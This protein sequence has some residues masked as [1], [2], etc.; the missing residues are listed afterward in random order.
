MKKQKTFKFTKKKSSGGNTIISFDFDQFDGLHI[1]TKC[2]LIA[3]ILRELKRYFRQPILNEEIN[4]RAINNV[5]EYNK[6][7][8]AEKTLLELNYH[9]AIMNYQEFCGLSII[10]DWE[11]IVEMLEFYWNKIK[12]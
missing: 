8:L 9:R 5:E 6:N 3:M 2:D 1:G 4:F 10:S 11:Q 7:K 12:V